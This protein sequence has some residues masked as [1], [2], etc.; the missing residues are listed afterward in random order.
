MAAALTGGAGIAPSANVDDR[1]VLAEPVHGNAGRKPGRALPTRSAAIRSAALL[2][3]YLGEHEAAG[4]VEGAVRR[5]LQKARR[6]VTW[7]AQARMR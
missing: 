1:F 2:L 3:G 7:A 4:A 6:R 5:A